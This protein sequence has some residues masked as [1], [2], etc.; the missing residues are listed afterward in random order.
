[1]RS[2]WDGGNARGPIARQWNVTTWP[3]VYLID[4]KGTI[5]NKFVG[6]PDV[7]QVD[8]AVDALMKEA[9]KGQD[10]RP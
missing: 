8:D 10:T 6:V 1:M 7:E 2:W 4:G 9:E 5:R 3:T